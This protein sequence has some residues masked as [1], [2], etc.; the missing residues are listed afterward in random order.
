[1]RAEQIDWIVSFR[2]MSLAMETSKGVGVG[3]E[4]ERKERNRNGDE[5]KEMENLLTN[6]IVKLKETLK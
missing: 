4:R 3:D 5:V 6:K 2:K 1:M